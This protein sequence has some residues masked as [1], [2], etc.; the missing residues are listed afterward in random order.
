MICIHREWKIIFSRVQHHFHSSLA[1]FS[2]SSFCFSFNRIYSY[3][4]NARWQHNIENEF[5]NLSW[6]FCWI[7]T[8]M[9]IF[10]IFILFFKDYL[11]AKESMRACT[12]T[13]WERGR[14]VKGERVPSRPQCGL[15]FNSR[16]WPESPRCPFSPIFNYQR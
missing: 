3:Y 13:W 2:F 1:Y 9:L 7:S 12:R 15:N 16:S 6:Q 4:S 11:F 10:P 8:F 5:H 14:E